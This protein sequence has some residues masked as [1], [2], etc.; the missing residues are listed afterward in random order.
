MLLINGLVLSPIQCHLI[1]SI[2]L[3]P[4]WKAGSN[5]AR[6]EFNFLNE[7]PHSTEDRP[8]SDAAIDLEMY[9][10]AIR[11]YREANPVAPE[12]L[13]AA[14]AVRE[15]NQEMISRTIEAKEAAR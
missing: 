11:Q 15:A 2:R 5:E 7:R 13:T 8:A 1:S 4:H 10:E 9:S 14:L 3:I 6:I 12:V